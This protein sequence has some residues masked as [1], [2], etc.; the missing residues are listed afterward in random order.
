MEVGTLWK[1]GGSLQLSMI[2]STHSLTVECVLPSPC[3]NCHRL[4]PNWM[5]VGWAL[6]HFLQSH[7]QMTFK[8]VC[9]VSSARVKKLL[10]CFS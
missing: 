3:A 7:L 10:P 1:L 5:L 2:A 8:S 6:L 4:P 9:S